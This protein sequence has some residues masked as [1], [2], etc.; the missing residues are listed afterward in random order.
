METSSSPERDDIFGL[1]PSAKT[2]EQWGF[3]SVPQLLWHE[4]SVY[5]GHI[6]GPMTLAPISECLAVELSLP[7]LTNGTTALL[8]NL[9]KK[10]SKIKTQTKKAIVSV[11]CDI[12]NNSVRVECKKSFSF[13]NLSFCDTF[14]T[15]K[16]KQVKISQF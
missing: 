9:H 10:K 8:Q 6:R 3:F 5:N 7:V 14:I 16:K 11:N 4:E 13:A 1:C 12:S 2:T 15:T